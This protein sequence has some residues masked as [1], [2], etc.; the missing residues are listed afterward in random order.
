MDKAKKVY[1]EDLNFV[2]RSCGHCN[3]IILMRKRHRGELLDHWVSWVNWMLTSEFG[4]KIKVIKDKSHCSDHWH[5][6][7][8]E[9]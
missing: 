5:W 1:F 7:L 2:I 8:E 4:D 6:H 3:L 9:I